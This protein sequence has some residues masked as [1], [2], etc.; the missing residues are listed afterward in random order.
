[1]TTKKLFYIGQRNNPQLSKPYYIAY[2]QLSKTDAK[3]FRDCLYGS[4]HLTSFDNVVD[5]ENDI[6]RIKSEGFKV[7][8]NLR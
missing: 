3:K 2:G 7:S 6:I 5:F 4:I 8:V 1:M